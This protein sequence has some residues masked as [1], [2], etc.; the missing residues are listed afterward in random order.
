MLELRDFDNDSPA[1]W[2]SVFFDFGDGDTLMLDGVSLA[3]LAYGD[4]VWF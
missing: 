1:P 4:F 3:Q 2:D